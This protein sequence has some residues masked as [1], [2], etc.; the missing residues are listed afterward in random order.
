MDVSSRG[1]LLPPR[2]RFFSLWWADR[3][4]TVCFLPLISGQLTYL[5]W[6]RKEAFGEFILFFYMSTTLWPIYP[7]TQAASRARFHHVLLHTRG[8]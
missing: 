6:F 5:Y 2:A 8:K 3:T 1:G 7:P 4:R